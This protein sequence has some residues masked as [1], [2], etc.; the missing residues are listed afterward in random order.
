MLV[1]M[2][3]ALA[4]CSGSESSGERKSAVYFDRETKQL[5][6]AEVQPTPAVHP[7]TGRRTLVRALYCPQCRKWQAVP[8]DDVRN[9]HPRNQKCRKHGCPLTADGPLPGK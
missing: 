4:G 1:T 6:V 7:Q 2:T 8:P 3:S 9:G 5:V